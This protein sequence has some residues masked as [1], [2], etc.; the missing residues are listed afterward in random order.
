M[1]IDSFTSLGSSFGT[2]VVQ[3]QFALLPGLHKLRENFRTTVICDC[4]V[5]KIR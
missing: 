5:V 2:S 3:E 1:G 4:D